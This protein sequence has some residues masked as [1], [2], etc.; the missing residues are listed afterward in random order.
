MGRKRIINQELREIDRL[1]YRRTDKQTK[2]HNVQLQNIGIDRQKWR[3]V[4]AQVGR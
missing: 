2:K 1:N 3:V 4:R